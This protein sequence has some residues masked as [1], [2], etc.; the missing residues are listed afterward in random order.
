MATPPRLSPVEAFVC[1][2]LVQ[3]AVKKLQFLTVIGSGTGSQKDELSQFMGDEIGRIIKEQKQL[4]KN[5]EELVEKRGELR[6]LS[7]KSKWI[8]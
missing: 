4:E 6:G 1:S 3:E 5:Y 2:T 7:S 8:L